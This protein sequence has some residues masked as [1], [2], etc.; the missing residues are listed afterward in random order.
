MPGWRVRLSDHV[1]QELSRAR[2]GARDIARQTSKRADAAKTAAAKALEAARQRQAA[3]TATHRKVL[4]TIR[5]RAESEIGGAVSELEDVSA[6]LT[7][8]AAASEWSRW[9]PTPEAGRHTTGLLRVGELAVGTAAQRP[10]ALI[11]VLDRCHLRIRADAE[12]ALPGILLR[13][14]GGAE[15]GAVRL[16]VYDPERLGGSLAGF[17]PLAPCG[18]LDFVGPHG[19][20]DMLDTHVE[21]VRRVNAAVLAGDHESLRE[22]AL[23]TGRRPEPWRLLVLLGAEPEE[24][25]KDQRAQLARIRRTG[26]A[27]GVHVIV[28][29]SDAADDTDT[30]QVSP[31]HVSLAGAAQIRLDSPPPQ[32]LVSTTC[33]TLAQQFAAGPQ[34]TRLSDLLTSQQWD[35]SSATGVSAPVGEGADGR[36]T[37]VALGDNPPHALVGGPSGAGKTNLLYTWIGALAWRYHPEELE[38][39]LLDFKEGVSFARFAGG[40]RDPS[41][42]PHVKLVGVNVNDD[43][44]FGLALLRYLREEMRRRA[45]AAKHHEAAKLEE[46]RTL[47]PQGRWPRIM[48]VVDEFQVLLEGRDEVSAEAVSLLEDLARRGRSQ[49]IH[50]VLASQDVAGIE[51]LWGRPS[52]IAQFTLRIA[53]PKARRLLADGNNLA[54]EIPRHHA[55]VNADSGVVE[56][57]QVVRLPDAGDRR[58]WDSLQEKLWRA[59]PAD[60][61]SPLLFDGDHVPTLPKE[62]VETVA[63]ATPT[64]VLGQTID[65]SSKA[66]TMR[67]TRAPGRNLAVLGAR[68]VEAC[69][70]L[71]S[72]A[73]SVARRHVVDVTMCCLDPDA[74]PAAYRLAGALDADGTAVDWKDS[75]KDVVEHW[76]QTRHDRLQLVLLYAADAVGARLGAAGREQLREMLLSGPERRVHTVGWWR[77]VPR[78]R[79][80]LGGFAARFDAVDAWIALDVQGP[81]LAP[82]SPQPGGPAWFPRARRGLYFD[83][84]VH[85]RPEVLIPFE[86]EDALPTVD[87]LLTGSGVDER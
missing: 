39:Y 65:V 14:L 79:E 44:E 31:T 10:A 62:S 85:R 73:M 18:L 50:L 40:R 3:L 75:L 9:E 32:Q 60:N 7:G 25:N 42:L 38:F 30:M 15:P 11:A 1:A 41:W 33:R 74:A 21:H 36:L 20:T 80:D 19:L 37:T 23:A 45:E 76:Q 46:L 72:A 78:L 6:D 24:W 82:L 53:L 34:P 83:R 59:R 57:N 48:A 49:G 22:L 55:V 77:S 70:V 67:L 47:D 12:S 66:A 4:G 35:C 86:T 81:E 54:D 28:V 61:D 64:A 29:G 17:A 63:E 52:L 8:C 69:D 71:A 68:R 51:A 2:G 87:D 13:I 16:T 27:C 56:A 26:V 84:A 58:A 5:D 43:R